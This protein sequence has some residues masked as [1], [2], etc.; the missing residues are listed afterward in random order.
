MAF[1]SKVS[2]P[3]NKIQLNNKKPQDNNEIQCNK[4]KNIKLNINH[5]QTALNLF[6]L[7]SIYKMNVFEIYFIFIEAYLYKNQFSLLLLNHMF[8]SMH[9]N[10]NGLLF[11]DVSRNINIA[12]TE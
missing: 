11:L 12:E 5:I 6:L 8:I 2:K 9:I 4:N 1:N 3:N 7:I 10:F